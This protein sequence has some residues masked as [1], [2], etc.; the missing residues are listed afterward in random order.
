MFCHYKSYI[1]VDT[2]IFQPLTV[3]LLKPGLPRI[4]LQCSQKQ[5]FLTSVIYAS[6]VNCNSIRFHLTQI[7]SGTCGS[8]MWFFLKS[9]MCCCLSGSG[10]STH[11]VITHLFKYDEIMLTQQSIIHFTL[12]DH[13]V[14][15][16]VTAA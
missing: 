5:S 14:L 3:R 4:K 7:W 11:T 16:G 1:I 15:T 8:G 9:A 2:G 10:Y 6:I 13:Y 12:E